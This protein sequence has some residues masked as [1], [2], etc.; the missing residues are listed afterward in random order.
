MLKRKLAARSAALGVGNTAQ[1]QRSRCPQSPLGRPAGAGR[2]VNRSQ[3]AGVVKTLQEWQDP[4]GT[5][6]A[7]VETDPEGSGR[8]HSEREGGKRPQE[9]K[10]SSETSL[11]KGE[12]TN[13][14]L[15]DLPKDEARKASRTQNVE[16]RERETG[17]HDGLWILQ[18]AGKL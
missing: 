15:R 17:G 1:T 4:L 9:R 8:L 7:L 3:R 6:R 11:R 5:P 2:Q 13:T 18:E 14:K 10:S 12:Y 16:P